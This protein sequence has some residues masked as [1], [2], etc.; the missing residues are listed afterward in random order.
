MAMM[1][2]MAFR[3][4]G[5]QFEMFEARIGARLDRVESRLDN[6][7]SRL[8]TIET[9]IIRIDRDVQGIASRVF[10]DERD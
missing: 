5:G 10:R 8:G 4:I 3:Y 2:H 1:F 6:V 9:E 7:E